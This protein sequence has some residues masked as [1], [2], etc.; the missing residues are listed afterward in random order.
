MLLCHLARPRE[1]LF[2]TWGQLQV[3][4]ALASAGW[5]LGAAQTSEPRDWAFRAG[6]PVEQ[7]P[8]PKCCHGTLCGLPPT[9][10][11]TRGA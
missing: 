10:A 1:E 2:L 9:A 7:R 3:P 4:V 11:Q 6:H 8:H 5:S